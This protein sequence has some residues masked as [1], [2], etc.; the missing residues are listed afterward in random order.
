MNFLKSTVA[1]TIERRSHGFL[2]RPFSASETV[3][4]LLK[5]Q[6]EAEEL[7]IDPTLS[8]DLNDEFNA[9]STNRESL[10]RSHLEELLEEKDLYKYKTVMFDE[11]KAKDENAESMGNSNFSSRRDKK[12]SIENFKFVIDDS[13]FNVL[14]EPE[15]KLKQRIEEENQRD[16]DLITNMEFEPN[17]QIQDLSEIDLIYKRKFW[18]AD[19]PFLNRLNIEK[20]FIATSKSFEEVVKAHFGIDIHESSPEKISEKLNN[21]SKIDLDLLKALCDCTFG[22][23]HLK[24]YIDIYRTF[25]ASQSN[26]EIPDLK[27]CKLATDLFL[28]KA[29][30]ELRKYIYVYINDVLKLMADY[31]H[32]FVMSDIKNVMMQYNKLMI[33]H[34]KITLTKEEFVKFISTLPY[35][36]LLSPNKNEIIESIPTLVF[37]FLNIGSVEEQA[38]M[39]IEE[40]YAK[41]DWKLLTII[42]Y[43]VNLCVRSFKSMQLIKQKYANIIVVLDQKIIEL[44]YLYQIFYANRMAYLPPLDDKL[45]KNMEAHCKSNH[46]FIMIANIIEGNRHCTFSKDDTKFSAYM[47]QK[48]TPILDIYSHII[49]SL[50]NHKEKKVFDIETL[51]YIEEFRLLIAAFARPIFNPIVKN[52]FLK[53]LSRVVKD[54][55]LLNIFLKRISPRNFDPLI[56]FHGLAS[57]EYFTILKPLLTDEVIFTYLEGFSFVQ[58]NQFYNFYSRNSPVLLKVMNNFCYF[59]IY[60]YSATSLLRSFRKI[61]SLISTTSD[62]FLEVDI[63]LT[64]LNFDVLPFETL[65]TI[66]QNATAE[67][68]SYRNLI[69]IYE[70]LKDKDPEIEMLFERAHPRF[71]EWY[72]KNDRDYS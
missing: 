5:E 6:K 15:D 12:N 27:L 1:K 61:S 26:L 10:S 14:L 4:K 19:V 42:I 58:Y 7:E 50:L 3:V 67:N 34:C 46:E 41:Q 52:Q 20:A 39:L 35:A 17:V 18:A 21:P 31:F 38:G 71:I 63:L 43:L 55:Y 56:L 47:N 29:N 53:I 13:K 22:A 36:L 68:L 8:T 64:T 11:E 16:I 57:V 2:K 9:Q 65:S 33:A 24:Y 44:P 66:L 30:E 70:Y 28:K 32:F 59:P 40:F 72:E 25:L 60:S 54:P 69:K 37:K 23:K 51:T 49:E 62:Y 45:V 48:M